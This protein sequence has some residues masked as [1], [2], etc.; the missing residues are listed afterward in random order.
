MQALSR[1]LP[2]NLCPPTCCVL[3]PLVQIFPGTF[4][5][6]IHPDG[7]APVVENA[8][9]V[10]EAVS[11]DAPASAADAAEPRAS[12]DTALLSGVSVPASVAACAVYSPGRPRSF[13]FPSIDYQPKSSS[14][15]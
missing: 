6:A 12:G 13:V 5:A 10:P 2:L 4:G 9:T 1:S 7:A 15:G 3:P 8:A 11:F 14:S